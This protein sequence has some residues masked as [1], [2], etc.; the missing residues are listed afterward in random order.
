MEKKWRKKRDLNS[1]CEREV[2][3]KE[4][5]KTRRKIEKSFETLLLIVRVRAVTLPLKILPAL[6][7]TLLVGATNWA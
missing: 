1:R 4:W 2:E 7:V 6:K 5:E 3:R